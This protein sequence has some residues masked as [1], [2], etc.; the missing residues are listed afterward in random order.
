VKP[1]MGQQ[2]VHRKM[3]NLIDCAADRWSV[4]GG[5]EKA[6]ATAACE[7]GL[8]PWA[9][10]SGNYGL[11]QIRDWNAAAHSFLHRDWFPR[12]KHHGVMPRWSKGRANA[13]A[14]VRW[15]HAS[16]WGAWSCA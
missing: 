2:T 5:S 11:F 16:G 3:R 13:I 10:G 15:A 4:P 12:W 6:V 8:W 1:R 9:Q 7:S 14:A